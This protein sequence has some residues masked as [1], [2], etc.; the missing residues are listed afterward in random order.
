LLF[1]VS[2]QAPCT[3][4]QGGTAAGA[5][6]ES[7]AGA[8]HP[9]GCQQWLDA[10]DVQHTR[11]IVAEYI[12]RHFGRYIGQSLHQKVRR[13]HPHL[14]GGERM[15]DGFAA[16]THGLWV[17]IEPRLRGLDDVF[18]FP[19]FDTALVGGCALILENRQVRHAFVK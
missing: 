8:S 14:Q 19:A 18:V 16:Q 17:L 4:V 12:Q 6:L 9:H 11:E 1:C 3:F 13:T 10:D 5:A 2:H 7:T 15:L